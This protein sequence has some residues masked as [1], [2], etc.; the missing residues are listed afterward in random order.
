[1]FL[2]KSQGLPLRPLLDAVVFVH[3]EDSVRLDR[4]IRR[5]VRERGRT[6]AS[7][8]RQWELTVAPMHAEFIEPVRVLADLSVRGDESSA[9]LASAV[10][11]HLLH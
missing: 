2:Q 1:M 4:R 8:R 3:L 9:D 7:I 11:T 10:A 6:E 5:D